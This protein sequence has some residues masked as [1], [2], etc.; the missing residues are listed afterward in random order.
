MELRFFACPPEI[1]KLERKVT[2]MDADSSSTG[3]GRLCRPE[4][5]PICGFL[6]I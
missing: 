4:R 5:K 2:D 3:A 1:K 6:E